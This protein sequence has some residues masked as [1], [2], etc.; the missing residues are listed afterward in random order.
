[1]GT[2]L[3][4]GTTNDAYGQTS[5]FLAAR[6]RGLDLTVTAPTV[7]VRGQ[8]LTF[9]GSFDDQAG[10]RVSEVTWSFADGTRPVTLTAVAPQALTPAHT[11]GADGTYPIRLTVRYATGLSITTTATVTIRSAALEA[12]PRDRALTDLV[13]GGTDRDDTILFLPGDR[14]N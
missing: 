3:V 9:T 10:A 8:A 2:F 4:A 5:T 14:S 11:Y 13:V 6:F 12:D 7:G 1:D